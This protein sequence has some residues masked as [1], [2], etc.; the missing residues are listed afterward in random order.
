MALEY[1]TAQAVQRMLLIIHS[2]PFA[3]L[4]IGMHSQP[5]VQVPD[6]IKDRSYAESGQA[7]AQGCTMQCGGLHIADAQMRTCA[8]R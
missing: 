2:R 1:K 6:M 7:P 8:G 4:C 5:R 3:L